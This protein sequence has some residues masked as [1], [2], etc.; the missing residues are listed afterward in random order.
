MVQILQLKVWNAFQRRL[1]TCKCIFCFI[2]L[3]L[4]FHFSPKC[5]VWAISE[6]V[7]VFLEA[8]TYFSEGKNYILRNKTIW[9]VGSAFNTCLDN[10]E[11]YTFL[12]Y[13]GKKKQNLSGVRS[14]ACVV[15]WFFYYPGYPCLWWRHLN[16]TWKEV[17]Q[18]QYIDV[19]LRLLRQITHNI[20][21]PLRQ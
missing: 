3:F 18:F 12:Y 13:S 8:P 19:L 4:L 15:C 7:H 9:D 16:C 14:E 17:W 21:R 20:L 5:I 10:H 6:L 1:P 11:W 2:C